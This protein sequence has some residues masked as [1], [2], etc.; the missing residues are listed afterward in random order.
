MLSLDRGGS[1]EGIVY[2][3]DEARLPADLAMLIEREPPIPPEWIEVDT[4]SGRVSALAFVCIPGGQ[5]HI[6]D[7]TPAAIARQIA[8]AVGLFG[9]MADYVL[10]TASHLEEMGIADPAVWQMQDLVAAEL[11]A[12]P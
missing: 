7:M 10:N 3:L 9:S 4:A 6:A 8:P 12:M 11:E 2:R 1:C 5:G